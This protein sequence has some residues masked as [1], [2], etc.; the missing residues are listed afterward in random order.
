MFSDLKRQKCLSVEKTF[1]FTNQNF[2]FKRLKNEVILLSSNIRGGTEEDE[3]P[4]PERIGADKSNSL[5]LRNPFK[6]GRS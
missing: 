1:N 6:Y 4:I 2:P 3:L 5:K